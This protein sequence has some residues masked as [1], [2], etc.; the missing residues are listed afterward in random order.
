MNLDT[1]IE[2]LIEQKINETV[3]RLGLHEIK[4]EPRKCVGYTQKQTRE[5]L[6]VSDET[7]TCLAKNGI[8]SRTKIGNGWRYSADEIDSFI[9]NH[10]NQDLSGDYQIQ[11]AKAVKKVLHP[12]KKLAL[13][14][15]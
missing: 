2:S 7:L 3:V 10:V 15:K 11:I 12:S 5:L 1:Y 6:Q 8:L 9:K 4:S 13:K 14:H